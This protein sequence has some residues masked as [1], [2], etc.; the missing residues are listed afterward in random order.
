MRVKFL[1]HVSGHKNITKVP[2]EGRFIKTGQVMTFQTLFH[3]G[4]SGQSQFGPLGQRTVP[5]QDR[6]PASQGH[7]HTPTPTQMGRCGHDYS[8]DKHIFGMWEGIQSLE[9]THLDVG[10]TTNVPRD[11][12]PS[13][14]SILFFINE[15]YDKMTLNKTT[16][17]EDH[18]SYFQD[19]P[20]FCL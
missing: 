11:S 10:R 12:A 20:L 19:H 4:W 9:N 17:L 18:Y 8:P 2:N 5:I 13:R 7:S 14:G 1:Q 16:F 15:H 3:P 6:S